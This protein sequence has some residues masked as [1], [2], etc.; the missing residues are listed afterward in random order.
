MVNR[1]H[2]LRPPRDAAAAAVL[3]LQP[4]AASISSPLSSDGVGQAAATRGPLIPVQGQPIHDQAVRAPPAVASASSNPPTT[5]P[6]SIP[7]LSSVSDNP[8]G[9]SSVLSKTMTDLAK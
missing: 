7:P 3:L 9:L 4:P 8:P 2:P 6:S 5:P 1:H